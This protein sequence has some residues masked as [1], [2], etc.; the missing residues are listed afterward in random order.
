MPAEHEA[1]HKAE[2][3]HQCGEHKGYPG[4][5]DRLIRTHC[6]ANR[7]TILTCPCG[8]EATT[9]G[10][11]NCACGRNQVAGLRNPRLTALHRAYRA[12][13]KGRW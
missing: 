2:H 10:P 5:G 9:W 3:C 8:A 1:L 7:C 11:L 4:H 13:R 12:K 6:R